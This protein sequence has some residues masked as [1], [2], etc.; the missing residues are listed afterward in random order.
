MHSLREV[1]PKVKLGNIIKGMDTISIRGNTSLEITGITKDSRN[2]SEGSLFFVTSASSAYTEDAF[3]RGAS[4][5]VTDGEIDRAVRMRRSCRGCHESTRTGCIELLS[6]SLAQGPYHGHHRN[7][8][9][10][11]NDVSYRVDLPR[12]PAKN[13]G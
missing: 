10:D 3:K 7:E 4:A 2:V 12:R 8:R 11:D 13:P 6:P 1:I 9:Q 5:I